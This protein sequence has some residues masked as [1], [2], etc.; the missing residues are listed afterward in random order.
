MNIC[1]CITD[2]LCSI[3]ETQHC[4]SRILQY[5][6]KKKFNKKK[7]Y[8]LHLQP[9]PTPWCNPQECNKSS[10]VT[11][12]GALGPWD[13][14]FLGSHLYLRK[15]KKKKRNSSLLLLDSSAG[16]SSFKN[17]NIKLYITLS[18]LNISLGQYLFS[19]T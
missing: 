18:F 14:E 2:S 17:I 5:K 3:P 13:L 16:M 8:I 4:K 12:G 11:W 6:I 9:L 15:K 1:V 19:C 7:T 10:V